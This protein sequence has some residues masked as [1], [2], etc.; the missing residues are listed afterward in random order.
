MFKPSIDCDVPADRG[1]LCGEPGLASSQRLWV[2]ATGVGGGQ[3]GG[4][5]DWW[6]YICNVKIIRSC[7]YK[8]NW[9][10][11]KK[12]WCQTQGSDLSLTW[13]L[14]MGWG[15]SRGHFIPVTW[16]AMRSL[17]NVHCIEQQGHSRV[18]LLTVSGCHFQEEVGW[19]TWLQGHRAVKPQCS[20]RKKV[21]N[22]HVSGQ[23]G[24]EL[25][26]WSNKEFENF[27][28]NFSTSDPLRLVTTLQL[29]TSRQDVH[30]G[31]ESDWMSFEKRQI[32][33]FS[34]SAGP[35]SLPWRILSGTSCPKIFQ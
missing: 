32:C 29:W 15:C 13:K 2:F 24:L 9:P 18:P 11:R 25:E 33:S 17:C 8:K 4:E 35:L 7:Q 19:G 5:E 23:L 30:E 20:K 14:K 34:S 26:L 31:R 27:Q 3:A 21:G 22:W 12:K 6:L 16:S 10:L 1:K 28:M